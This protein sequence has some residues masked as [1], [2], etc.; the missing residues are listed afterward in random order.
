M[1]SLGNI[2]VLFYF[3][4]CNSFSRFEYVLEGQ[5]LEKP[6]CLKPVILT[7]IVDDM[8]SSVRVVLEEQRKHPQEYIK[9]SLRN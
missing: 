7:E 6:P 5:D 9:V 8:K 4:W 3:G 2:G 1:R